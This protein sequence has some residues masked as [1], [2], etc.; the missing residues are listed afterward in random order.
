MSPDATYHP[1]GKYHL[2][3]RLLSPGSWQHLWQRLV[4]VRR[5]LKLVAG[6]NR[7]KAAIEFAKSAQA[8]MAIKHMDGGQLDGAFVAVQ[9]SFAPSRS[10]ASATVYHILMAVRSRN[11]P[12]LHLE[13][14][15]PLL[16]L[17]PP[18]GDIHPPAVA[19]LRPIEDAG[20]RHT[21]VHLAQGVLDRD[22]DEGGHIPAR[23]R[24]QDGVWAE[25]P[26]LAEEAGTGVIHSAGEILMCPAEEGA[27]MVV[28]V[29]VEAEGAGMGTATGVEAVMAVQ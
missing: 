17:S 19:L 24:R 22:T 16:H 20:P 21:P 8:E 6:L 28:M 9:V 25:A 11:I 29:V 13:R 12:Y 23:G 14:P 5:E 2:N 1:D 10:H 26:V 3:E 4:L 15:R 27:D 7:G 18:G